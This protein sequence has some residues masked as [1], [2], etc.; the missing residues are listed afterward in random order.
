MSKDEPNTTPEPDESTQTPDEST[1]LDEQA[2]EAA[3]VKTT[4]VVLTAPPYLDAFTAG[5]VTVRRGETVEVTD[6]ELAQITEAAAVN[7]V[8]LA[9]LED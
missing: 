5:D 6:D 2:P 9:F 7:G 8:C 3:Q 1:Q 4:K